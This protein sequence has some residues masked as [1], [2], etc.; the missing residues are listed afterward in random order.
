MMWLKILGP[1]VI[2][3]LLFGMGYEVG[4]NSKDEEW[5][6]KWSD[7]DAKDLA[8][9]LA[10][11]KEIREQEQKYVA[12]LD[13]ANKNGAK[14]Q[15]ELNNTIAAGASI[16]ERLHVEYEKLAAK[17]KRC[18]KTTI[19]NGGISTQSPSDMLANLLSRCEQRTT[20]ISRYADELAIAHGV[21]VT[22]YNSVFGD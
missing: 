11:E 17:S 9:N 21:C 8:A 16:T 1:M 4:S 2:T 10:H 12:K 3:A 19:V 20:E 18:E 15:E 13:E 14:L 6:L 5:K 7:R 22:S